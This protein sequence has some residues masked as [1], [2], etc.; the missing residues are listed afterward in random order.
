MYNINSESWGFSSGS[1]VKNPLAIAEDMCSNPDPGR[2]H[3]PRSNYAY[4]PHLLN[5]ALAPGGYNTEVLEP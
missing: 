3:M 5:L 2:S 1:V 4:A